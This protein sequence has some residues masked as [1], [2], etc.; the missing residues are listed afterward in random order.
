MF[1]WTRDEFGG[2]VAKVGDV[3]L[4]ASPD[5]VKFGKPV[6]GTK[7]RASAT[8][9]DEAARCGTRYG[10]DE[11]MNLQPTAKAAMKLAEDIYRSETK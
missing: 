11:Y 8:R 2:Y 5:R 7:W 3:L 10:R 9:I 4:G 6:R 1:D